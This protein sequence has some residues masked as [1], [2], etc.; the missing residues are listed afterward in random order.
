MDKKMHMKKLSIIVTI[1]G[2]MGCGPKSVDLLRSSPYK[3]HTV[4]VNENHKQTF[5]FLQKRI[6]QCYVG[7]TSVT[8][9]ISGAFVTSSTSTEVIA[10]F[11]EEGTSTIAIKLKGPGG[12]VFVGL[13]DIVGVENSKSQVNISFHNSFWDDHTDDIKAWL[14][15]N[16]EPCSGKGS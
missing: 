1:L 14:N 5:S 12:P 16:L 13:V 2:L 15:G 10:S 4:V 3:K 9:P 11:T 6:S 8:T 7:T